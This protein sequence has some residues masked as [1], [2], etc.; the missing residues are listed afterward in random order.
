MFFAT[1]VHDLDPVLFRINDA[2]ALRWY[3]LSYL[4]AF[5]VGMVLLDYLAKRKLWVLPPGA[6]GDFIAAAAIFGVFI[7]GRLGYM[8]WYEPREHG[9]SWVTE[10]PLRVF[11][12]WDGGMASHGGILGLVIF[13]WFYSRKKK[14][15]WTGLGDGL[16][17]VAPLGIMFGRLANFINGELYGRVAE[18]VSWAVKFPMALVE[19]DR[20]ES[21][22][23]DAAMEAVLAVRPELA[24]VPSRQ[25]FTTVHQWQIH[26]PAVTQA[27]EP[28]LEPRHPSQL[29]QA[30]MEGLALF[31]I[32]WTVRVRFPR[33]PHGVLTGL[34]FIGYAVFRII[35]EQFRE[36]DSSKSFVG[37]FTSGQFLS[38]F[39]IAIGALFIS[40]AVTRKRTA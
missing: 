28:F 12:V 10:D 33:L 34:F 24:E 3:G 17:V 5:L 16:C 39:M 8:L 14:V 19:P 30:G 20:I 21:T 6:A 26:D 9:W 40:V 1:Y 37:V 18:G 13:T 27:L 15:S 29:Y 25:W 36:P 4:A 38:L 35:G 22:R 7:G 11:R 23:F 31:L 32:L 2:I